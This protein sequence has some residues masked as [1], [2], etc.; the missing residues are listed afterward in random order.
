[1]SI[2]ASEKYCLFIFLPVKIQIF[3][4]RYL[5]SDENDDDNEPSELKFSEEETM[6][7]EHEEYE[8]KYNF[9]FEEPDREFVSL[10]IALSLYRTWFIMP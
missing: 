3:F 5:E 9:R 10:I 2:R 8:H 4:R 7:N 1:M 6:L